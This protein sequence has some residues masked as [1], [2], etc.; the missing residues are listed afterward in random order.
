MG[1]HGTPIIKYVKLL[2]LQIVNKMDTVVINV[3]KDINLIFKLNNV[4]K[5]AKIPIVLNV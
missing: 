3:N 1:N 4:I 5:Y 2:L